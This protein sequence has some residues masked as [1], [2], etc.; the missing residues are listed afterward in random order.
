M[1]FK[2]IAFAILSSVLLISSCNVGVDPNHDLEI[3]SAD[4]MPMAAKNE[5]A[6]VYGIQ[7]EQYDSITGRIQRDSYLSTL[8]LKYGVSMQ[9]IDKALYNSR[10]IFDVRKVRPGTEYKILCE[11]S[12]NHRARYMI[13][14]HDP[15]LTYVFSFND[16]LNITEFRK[17]V[18]TQIKYAKGTISTSLWNAI[19]DGG[20]SPALAAELNEIFQWTVDFFGL[21]QG[22]YFK[23]VYEEKFIENKSMGIGKI[24][25]AEFTSSGKTYTAIPFIQD[26]KESFFDVDGKSLK[27]EFLKA[28]LKFSRISSRYTTSRMHPVLKIR[29]PHLGV[30]YAAPLG[31]PVHAVGDGKVISATYDG[32]N[33]R[34]VKIKHNSAYSTAYLHLSRFGEGISAGKMVKQGDIIG[35]VGSTGLSTG[36]HLDFRFYLN[37]APVDP[38]KVIAPPAEPVSE[39]NARRFEMI[40]DVNLSLLK[41]M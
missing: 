13:Y 36:P 22:D 5:P 15:A 10:D 12:G 39:A 14:E 24:L 27:K 25:T 4:S 28:P 17:P 41:T 32:G 11:K 18:I 20:M 7:S 9:E 6:S 23:V 31:T 26:G 34:M 35:Y 30:D 3:M 33:G 38:L 21:E 40:R 16:S 1:K 2:G 37:G 19:L 29:R 8:L